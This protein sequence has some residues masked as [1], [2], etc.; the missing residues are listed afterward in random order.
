MITSIMNSKINLQRIKI[1]RIDMKKRSRIWNYRMQD[2]EI[3]SW[4]WKKLID[5]KL[6]ILKSSIEIFSKKKLPVFCQ[7]MITKSRLLWQRSIGRTGYWETRTKKF[8]IWLE[9]KRSRKLKKNKENLPSELRLILLKTNFKLKQIEQ[10]KK[11]K[12]IAEESL[13]WQMLFKEIVKLIMT[14]STNS[15]KTSTISKVS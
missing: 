4:S 10:L 9:T 1:W 14:E 2:S 5:Q 3:R 7:V 6:S 11:I 13:T 15:T 12:K 8:K